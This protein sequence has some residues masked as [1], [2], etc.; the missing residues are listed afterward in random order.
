VIADGLKELLSNI[1]HEEYQ[2]KIL[3]AILPA[4][5]NEFK[6]SVLG[7]DYLEKSI[8]GINCLF[9]ID[10]YLE[11]YEKSKVVE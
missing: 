3:A 2:E 11:E 4:F 9:K 5:A 8:K 7:S 10:K 6:D 1:D